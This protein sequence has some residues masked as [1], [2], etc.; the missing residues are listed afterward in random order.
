MVYNNKN[1]KDTFT[2]APILLPDGDIF[3]Y[4]DKGFVYKIKDIYKETS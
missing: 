3:I 1:I 4:S 2:Q